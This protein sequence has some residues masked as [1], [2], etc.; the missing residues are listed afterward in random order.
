MSPVKI[1]LYHANWC[2]HCKNFIPQWN[3]LTKFFDEHNISYDDFED[4]RN[5]NEIQEAGIQGF[6]T[7]RINKNGN[8]YDYNGPR[9]ADAII[10]ELGIQLGGSNKE[11]QRI[12]IKYTKFN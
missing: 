2:G 3:A 10:N 5:S 8:E 7:I 9:T 4:K 1:T 6:P 11:I 12:F